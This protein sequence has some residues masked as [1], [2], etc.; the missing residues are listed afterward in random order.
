MTVADPPAA[1]E[2]V[3]RLNGDLGGNLVEYSMLLA[4]ILIA[5]LAAVS[6]FGRV[7]TSKTYCVQSAIVNEASDNC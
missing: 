2:P 6:M 1:F 4:L 7:T 3:N 5:C